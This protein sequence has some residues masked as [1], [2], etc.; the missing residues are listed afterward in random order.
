ME[1]RRPTRLQR[2]RM[3]RTAAPSTAGGPRT[4]APAPAPEIRLDLLEWLEGEYPDRAPLTSDEWHH[5]VVRAAQVELV[6]R[7]RTV[8]EEQQ[9]ARSK[10][11]S[12]LARR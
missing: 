5:I 2:D 7:L 1:D 8:Y 12:H 11:A 4:L 3:R 9:S 10:V 6:R